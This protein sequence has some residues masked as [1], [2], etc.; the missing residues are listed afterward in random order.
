M[1]IVQYCSLGARPTISK[2]KSKHFDIEAEDGMKRE[3]FDSFWNVFK[4]SQNVLIQSRNLYVNVMKNCLVQKFDV[5]AKRFNLGFNVLQMQNVLI[6][7]RKFDIKI[8]TDIN[9]DLQ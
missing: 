5:E 6:Q 7:S 1:Y 2:H 4:L 9:A 8:N 3:R